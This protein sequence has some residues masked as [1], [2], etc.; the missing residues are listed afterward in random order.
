MRGEGV[1]RENKFLRT[2]RAV[3]ERF[4]FNRSGRAKK[5]DF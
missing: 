1:A 3:D 4:L 5:K 2:M